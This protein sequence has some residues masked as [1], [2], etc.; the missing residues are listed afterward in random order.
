MYQ[1]LHSRDISKDAMICEVWRRKP[2]STSIGVLKVCTRI[3]SMNVDDNVLLV[4]RATE[5]DDTQ[6]VYAIV[7]CFLIS[8][9]TNTI[10]IR[11]N[12]ASRKFRIICRSDVDGKYATVISKSIRVT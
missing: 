7:Q 11:I 6:K 9:E 8:Q 4:N 12:T 1:L 3:E 5:T 10:P 2:S